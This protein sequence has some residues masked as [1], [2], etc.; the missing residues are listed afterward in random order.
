[1]N[2]VSRDPSCYSNSDLDDSTEVLYILI[3]FQLIYKV[4]IRIPA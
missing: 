1:M 4:L 2:G 3:V